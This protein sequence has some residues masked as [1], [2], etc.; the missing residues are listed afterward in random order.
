VFDELHELTVLRIWEGVFGRVI[1]GEH[2]TMAVIELDDSSVVPEH[3]HPHEQIGV[4][5]TGSVLYRVGSE[6]RELGPGGTWRIPG[7]TPHE[8]RAGPR[9]AVV[10]ETWAPRRDDWADLERVER[11]RPRWPQ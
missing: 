8:A 11:A 5:I 4:C 6:E 1:G 2:V 7:G 10:V 9:G 3:S